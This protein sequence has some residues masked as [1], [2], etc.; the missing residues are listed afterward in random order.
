MKYIDIHSHLDFASFGADQASVLARM[1]EPETVPKLSVVPE[2][3]VFSVIRPEVSLR[4]WPTPFTVLIPCVRPAISGAIL[5]H[6]VK[7]V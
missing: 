6:Y 5:T 7:K 4:P 3:V 1:K 2:I